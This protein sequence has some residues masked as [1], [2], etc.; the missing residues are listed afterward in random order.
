[1]HFI[2]EGLIAFFE[3]IDDADIE[4]ALTHSSFKG[5]AGGKGVDNTRLAF[6]GDAV[7]NLLEAERLFHE[8]GELPK[9]LMTDQ[10]QKL[11]S[12]DALSKLLKKILKL[13]YQIKAVKNHASGVKAKATIVEALFGLLSEKRGIESCRKLWKTLPVVDYLSDS[14]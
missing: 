2:N 7:I 8:E 1:M 13:D 4:K 6:L 5:T 9:G 12:D 10:R 11:V 14:H 3:E